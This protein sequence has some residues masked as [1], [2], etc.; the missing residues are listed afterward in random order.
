MRA[1]EFQM[2]MKQVGAA[3]WMADGRADPS[4]VAAEIARG[5]Q[6]PVPSGYW[7][8]EVITECGHR[9]ARS[10]FTAGDVVAESACRSWTECEECD[11]ELVCHVGVFGSVTFLEAA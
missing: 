11:R 4:L 8:V 10:G 9:M 3:R 7:G 1:D 5:P 2:T 6:V